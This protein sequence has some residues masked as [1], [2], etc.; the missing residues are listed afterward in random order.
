MTSDA[1]WEFIGGADPS[2]VPRSRRWATAISIVLMLAAVTLVNNSRPSNEQM[3]ALYNVP[4]IFASLF[5]GYAG[6]ILC[7][8]VATAPCVVF[9]L[10]EREPLANEVM[11]ICF[12]FIFASLLAKA[13]EDQRISRRMAVTDILTGLFNR[14]FFMQQLDLEFTRTQRH[15]HAL[16]LLMFDLDW[17]KRYNDTHGHLRGDML[18]TRVANLLKDGFRKTDV[19]GRY[20]GEEFIAMLPETLADEAALA[21]ERVRKSVESE[22]ADEGITVSIGLAGCTPEIRSILEFITY[23]DAALYT[24]KRDG[25]NCLRLHVAAVPMTGPAQSFAAAL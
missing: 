5:F 20:G 13:V 1:A 12:F 15:G 9:L 18:L 17:F 2:T 7:A 11:Q 6:G 16:S 23:A 14:R 3:T 24:A 25:R 22:L 8:M 4:I 21:A 19:F 10:R